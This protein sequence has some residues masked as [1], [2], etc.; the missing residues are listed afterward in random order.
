MRSVWGCPSSAG[1]DGGGSQTLDAKLVI[2]EGA[3]FSATAR[4]AAAI[5]PCSSRGKAFLVS[6]AG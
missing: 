5:Q 6:A 2:A 1:G 4:D 3:C